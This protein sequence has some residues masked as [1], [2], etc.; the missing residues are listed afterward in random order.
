MIGEL[1]S[2]MIDIAC[3]MAVIAVVAV[4]AVACEPLLVGGARKLWRFV[5][6]R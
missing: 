3:G 1:M 2:A 5:R 6:A 4:V